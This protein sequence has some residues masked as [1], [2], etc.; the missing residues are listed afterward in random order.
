[1][2]KL[3]D[4]LKKLGLSAAHIE[5]V[6]APDAEFD[7]DEVAGEATTNIQQALEN[8]EAF[9]GKLKGNWQGEVLS[10]KERYLMKA[11]NGLLTQAEIDALPKQDR[12]N[13]VV[14]LLVTK[15]NSSKP[16]NDDKD[17]EIDR[18]NKL[19]QERENELRTVREEELPKAQRE[20]QKVAENFHL[21][22]SILKAVQASGKKTVLPVDK[23]VDLLYADA[24]S[25]YDLKWDET[26]KAPKVLQKGKDLL[27]YSDKDRSKPLSVND[28]VPSIA[29]A[30]GYFVRNNAAEDENAGGERKTIAKKKDGA[31][32]FNLPGLKKAEEHAAEKA[33]AAKS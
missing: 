19:V 6:T 31:P 27:A 30:Q 33:S 8:D 26:T 14:D 29:E 22:E 32:R 12:F 2:K 23:T 5:T 7:V 4:L 24:L 21:R 3:K 13:K 1:M 10:S 20:A 17:K 28:I 11:S 15:L 25:A 18:L 9:I 16:A